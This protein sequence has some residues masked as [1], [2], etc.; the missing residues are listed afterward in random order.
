VLQE[1]VAMKRTP[2]LML[3]CLALAMTGC[4]AARIETGLPP[5]AKQIRQS[6]ASC[7]IYGL[8]PPKTVAVAA[9]CPNG[10]AIVETR[11]S[12]VNGLVRFLTLGIYTPMEIVVTCAAKSSA[13]LYG[14]EVNLALVEG[15]TAEQ[16]QEVFGKAADEA[17]RTGH[18]VCVWTTP[19]QF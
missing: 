16:A 5:D 1:E 13:S 2:I 7:L 17:V 12:F 10:V 14:A 8:V 18:P 9:Q 15:A 4:Y 3:V 19:V 11:Q 6:S